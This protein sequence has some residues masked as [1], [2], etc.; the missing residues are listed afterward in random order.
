M[1]PRL[2]VALMG[3]GLIFVPL[4]GAQT[5]TSKPKPSASVK[6]TEPAM[7]EDMREAIAFQR[8]K[9]IA[10]ARQARLEAEHPSVTYS[11]ANRSADRS[12]DDQQGTPVKDPGPK[13][14]K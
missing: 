8:N 14:D 6:Q 9:D 7:S 13:K 11:E 10:D 12:T 5:Q 1:K 4:A 2:L 3:A